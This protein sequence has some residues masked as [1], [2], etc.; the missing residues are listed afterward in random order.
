MESE[1]KASDE[2]TQQQIAQIKAQFP[3]RSLHRIEL[4]PDLKEG[5][6]LDTLVFVMTG[7]NVGEYEKYVED[8]HK[9]NAI[10]D[11][12]DRTRALRSAVQRNALAQIRWPDRDRVMD[13][14]ANYPAMSMSFAG[15]LHSTA[16]S[17][18]EV[19]SKKL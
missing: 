13:L 4:S 2:P 15:L 3:T 1:F 17:S 10:T 5:V 9:A 7:P 12:L 6:E 11:P 18:Y 8:V 14:F 16:G 19:R